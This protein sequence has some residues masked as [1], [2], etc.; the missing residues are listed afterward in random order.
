VKDGQVEVRDVG[1]RD[2][3]GQQRLV[4][5]IGEVGDRKAGEPDQILATDRQDVVVADE[6]ALGPAGNGDP[7]A[8]VGGRRRG[9]FALGCAEHDFDV[10]DSR[11][12][13]KIDHSTADRDHR[14][15]LRGGLPVDG[16]GA[17]SGGAKLGAEATRVR[18][19][20]GSGLLGGGDVGLGTT[21]RPEEPPTQA[22]DEDDQSGEV[23]TSHAVLLATPVSH[24]RFQRTNTSD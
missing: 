13:D 15:R 3:G 1:G 21:L 7:V 2:D 11:V 24:R 14:A 16:A 18:A 19:T 6:R 4:G 5:L 8:A 23:A 10:P 22:S 17:T 9:L 12:P 20:R